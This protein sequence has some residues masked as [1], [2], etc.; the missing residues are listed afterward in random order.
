ME[1]VGSWLS[2]IHN[3]FREHGYAQ[4]ILPGVFLGDINVAQNKPYLHALG[5]K[6]IV[7]TAKDVPNFHPND[8]HYYN[9]GFE[10]TG[11]PLVEPELPGLFAFIEAAL[12]RKE[13]V[14]IHCIGGVSRSATFTIAYVMT[15]QQLRFPQAFDHVRIRRQI[16]N[17]KPGFLEQLQ[18]YEKRLFDD[19]PERL[20]R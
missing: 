18:A 1:W 10:D 19:A 11:L 14:L 3:F 8:F 13:A 16:V 6:A 12:Q 17:P 9:I 2:W 20:W 4:E 7:N 5:I 15:K